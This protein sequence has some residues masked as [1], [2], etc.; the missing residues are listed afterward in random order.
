MSVTEDSDAGRV[1]LNY[2]PIFVIV[3]SYIHNQPKT[4]YIIVTLL[5]NTSFSDSSDVQQDDKHSSS[6]RTDTGEDQG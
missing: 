5:I 2:R 4:L 3:S 6:S 1:H